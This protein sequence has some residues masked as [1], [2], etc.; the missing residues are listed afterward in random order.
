[1]SGD[2]FDNVDSKHD[3]CRERCA[4]D[5]PNDTCKESGG[6]SWPARIGCAGEVRIDSVIAREYEKS[7][8]RRYDRTGAIKTHSRGG[9]NGTYNH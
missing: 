5:E 6:P 4:G 7:C 3:H 1:M 9:C 8:L 2:H